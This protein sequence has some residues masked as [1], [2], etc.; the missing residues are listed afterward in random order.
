MHP[1][2]RI[3]DLLASSIPSLTTSSLSNPLPLL[4][5]II[6]TAAGAEPQ[7]SQQPTLGEITLKEFLV[8]AIVVRDNPAAAAMAAVPA[9]PV[10]PRP[11]QVVSNGASMIRGGRGG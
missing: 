3:A 7:P 4:P 1:L 8:R 10:A 2:P 6:G 9:K 11:I 5:S